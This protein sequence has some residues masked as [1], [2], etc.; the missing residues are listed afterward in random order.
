MKVMRILIL[1][2]CLYPL[3]VGCV[4][5]SGSRG[6]PV[7]IR[8]GEYRNLEYNFGLREIPE[9]WHLFIETYEKSKYGGFAGGELLKFY[10]NKTLLAQIQVIP[11]SH[12]ASPAIL[13]TMKI[14]GLP[15]T[16][17]WTEVHYWDGRKIKKRLKRYTIEDD[18][19]VGALTDPE[20]GD[21]FVRSFYRLK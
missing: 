19:I 7:E 14:A 1:I 12:A 11:W 8:G 5:P 6:T 2:G 3:V 9:D 16:E 4:D 20:L 13:P 10:H 18:I 21:W 15:A 17:E